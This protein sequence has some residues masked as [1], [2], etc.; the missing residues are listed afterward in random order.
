[1]ILG[2]DTKS[3][4]RHSDFISI[5]NSF[6]RPRGGGKKGVKR[7][8]EGFVTDFVAFVEGNKGKIEP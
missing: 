8:R 3:I 4:F 2:L 7:G 5:S 6:L 1:M